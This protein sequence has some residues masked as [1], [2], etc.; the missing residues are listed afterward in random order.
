M[1]VFVDIKP[2]TPAD[3]PKQCW[4]STFRGATKSVNYHPMRFQPK[5]Q[6]L[7]TRRS[8]IIQGL[9]SGLGGQNGLTTV[10]GGVNF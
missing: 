4:F 7:C 9:S 8:F 1:E 6:A 2:R 10:N 5:N 3:L